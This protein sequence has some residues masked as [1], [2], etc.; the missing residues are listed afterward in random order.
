MLISRG[1]NDSITLKLHNRHWDSTTTFSHIIHQRVFKFVKSIKLIIFSLF[2]WCTEL[3]KFIICEKLQSKIIWRLNKL[4]WIFP[5]NGNDFLIIH[6]IMK[7]LNERQFIIWFL[8]ADKF[9]YLYNKILNNSYI[10][11]LL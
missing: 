6:S 10:M 11:L 1:F 3:M 2:M 4:N 7:I 8:Y 9:P 5:L